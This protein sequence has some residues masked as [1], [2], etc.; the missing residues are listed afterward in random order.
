MGDTL[1]SACQKPLHDRPECLCSHSHIRWGLQGSFLRHP[2]C[3][4]SLSLTSRLGDF[5]ARVG[6]NHHV[7]KGVIGRHGLGLI[8]TTMFPVLS[9]ARFIWR[10]QWMLMCRYS[11]LKALFI[12]MLCTMFDFFNIPVF[13]PILVLYFFIL[14]TITMKK[15][16]RV[17]IRILMMMIMMIC[18]SIVVVLA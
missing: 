2:S 4:S 8:A 18:Y 7:W 11:T 12:G 16:I 6:S 14:F 9:F 17:C 13:W 5:N 10:M 1:S 3:N 15:Q